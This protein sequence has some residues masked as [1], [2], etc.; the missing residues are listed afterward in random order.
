MSSPRFA[1]RF[2]L[3][4]ALASILLLQ[5][6]VGGVP[7]LTRT[8]FFSDGFSGVID[9]FN[10]SRR[11]GKREITG[12]RAVNFASGIFGDRN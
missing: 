2:I 5:E 3:H 4:S 11:G 1:L 10:V 6:F 9:S 7:K 8:G 12:L